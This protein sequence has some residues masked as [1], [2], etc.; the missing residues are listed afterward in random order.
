M[1]ALAASLISVLRVF[2]CSYN[3]LVWC[4]VYRITGATDG[5]CK[6]GQGVHVREHYSCFTFLASSFLLFNLCLNVAWLHSSWIIC[7][8]SRSPSTLNMCTSSPPALPAHFVLV[9]LHRTYAWHHFLHIMVI[10]AR[11]QHQFDSSAVI[12]L[13]WTCSTSLPISLQKAF[14]G[15][16]DG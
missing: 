4:C 8:Q 1:V 15:S 3:R 9:S 16:A 14:P 5:I 11:Q 7:E 10:E 2:L 13:L 12:S 6:I